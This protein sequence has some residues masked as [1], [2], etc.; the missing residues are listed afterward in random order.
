[1]MCLLDWFA[2]MF[3]VK[4]AVYWSVNIRLYNE[5]LLLSFKEEI[6]APKSRKKKAKRDVESVD[7]PDGE[8]RWYKQHIW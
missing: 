4:I 5:A 6:P 1:M 2:F 7:E 3:Q 8:F